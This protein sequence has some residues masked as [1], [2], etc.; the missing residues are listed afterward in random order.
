[1]KTVQTS[2]RCQAL[3]TVLRVEEGD[4]EA[5]FCPLR[6]PCLQK[7]QSTMRRDEG[8]GRR[9]GRRRSGWKNV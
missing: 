5:G 7:L 3:S 4:F 8:W 9:G 2:S 6:S 1:M